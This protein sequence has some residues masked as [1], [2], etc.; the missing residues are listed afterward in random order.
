M[1]GE[2]E[3]QIKKNYENQDIYAKNYNKLGLLAK[4]VKNYEN[5]EN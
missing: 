4:K 3:N 5:Y 1:L 2:S